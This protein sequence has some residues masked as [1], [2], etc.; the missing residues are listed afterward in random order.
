MIA[1]EGNPETRHGNDLCASHA[2]RRVVK[3]NRVTSE[4]EDKRRLK[5]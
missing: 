2:D 4:K 5:K 3:K 1:V